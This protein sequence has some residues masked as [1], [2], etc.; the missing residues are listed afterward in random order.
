MKHLI[1]LFSFCL[2]LSSFAQ[3]AP[4]DFFSK[5][6]EGSNV[7]TITQ[8]QHSEE[9]SEKVKTSELKL[10]EEGQLVSVEDYQYPVGSDKPIIL[11][12]EMKYDQE[13][14]RV[15]TYVEVV[16]LGTFIDSMIYNDQN[17]LIKKQIIEDGEV[18]QTLDYSEKLEKKEFDENGNLV[19]F[20][21]K[22]RDY[23]TYTYNSDDQLTEEFH[24]KDGKEL[25]K[26]SYRYDEKGFLASMETLLYNE[27]ATKDLFTYSFAYEEF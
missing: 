9:S 20:T 13:G 6:A 21:N 5:T 7:K 12:Q 18:L 16:N 3:E 4:Y 26:H 14:R 10:N 1:L 11:R 19:K 25:M 15:A 8:F 17:E 27:K 24:F 23:T 2:T 22:N